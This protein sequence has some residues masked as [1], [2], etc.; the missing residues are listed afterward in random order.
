MDIPVDV[1][2]LIMI[3][4]SKGYVITNHH[5]STSSYSSQ[6]SGVGIIVNWFT[7][8]IYKLMIIYLVYNATSRPSVV[9][10]GNQEV[11]ITWQKPLHLSGQLIRYELNVNGKVVYSGV[12]TKY[13][14]KTLAADEMYEF[15]VSYINITLYDCLITHI[16]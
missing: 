12:D 9:V 8:L 3:G 5:I 1:K 11:F 2:L 15:V 10:F 4:S 14:V 13:T 16:I 6:F 7:T